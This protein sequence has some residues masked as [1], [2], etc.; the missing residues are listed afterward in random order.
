VSY[1][2]K[3][4][5]KDKGLDNNYAAWERRLFAA[6]ASLC[7]I[8]LIKKGRTAEIDSLFIFFTDIV[9]LVWLNGY[10]RQWKPALFGVL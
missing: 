2:R 1:N 3:G 7:M 10:I 5:A 6:I 9:L 4:D 8:G